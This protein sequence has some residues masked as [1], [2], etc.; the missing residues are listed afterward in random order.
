M[1][2]SHLRLAQQAMDERA[3]L[4]SIRDRGEIGMTLRLGGS[5]TIL[6]QA[7]LDLARPIVAAE[8]TRRIAECEAD[9]ASY[10]VELA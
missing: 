3:R 2:A 5:V 10:G 1:K 9:L 4:I 7:M 6:D 8:L